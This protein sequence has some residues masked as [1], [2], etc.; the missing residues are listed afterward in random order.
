MT[1]LASPRSTFT[2]KLQTIIS[3]ERT[4]HTKKPQMSEESFPEMTTY[5]SLVPDGG[6]IR[7]LTGRLIVDHKITLT[8]TSIAYQRHAFRAVY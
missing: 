1:A 4:P 6:V 7:E 3:S 2:S 8:L 5:W